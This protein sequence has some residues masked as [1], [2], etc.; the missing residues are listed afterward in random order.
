LARQ[1]DNVKHGTD[2]PCFICDKT[3][4]SLAGNPHQWPTFYPYPGGNGKWRRYCTGCVIDKLNAADPL[5]DL[6]IRIRLSE[7]MV[8]NLQAG[9]LVHF[10]LPRL[11][12]LIQLAKVRGVAGE[13]EF[14]NSAEWD[15][16][17]EDFDTLFKSFGN[18]FSRRKK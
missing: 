3:T 10:R 17:W 16:L 4:C 7:E 2:G 13:Y 18:L 1:G 6:T 11:K 15:K 14:I 8:S 12:N 5:G 9:K